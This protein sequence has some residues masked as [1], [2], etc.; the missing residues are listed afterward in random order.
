MSVPGGFC[1]KR[2][3]GCFSWNSSSGGPALTE[4]SRFCE[5]VVAGNPSCLQRRDL[6]VAMRCVGRVGRYCADSIR[7]KASCREGFCSD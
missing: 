1:G 2:C 7:Y 6:N 4:A 3:L 5:R